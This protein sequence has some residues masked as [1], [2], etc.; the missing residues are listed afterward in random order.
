MVPDPVWPAPVLALVQLAD[1]IFC[2]I[3]TRFV[4]KC[5]DDVRLPARYRPLLPGLKLAA[6][7]G[8]TVGLWI[9]YL[10]AVTSACVAVYFVL[11]VGAH[12][13][14]KDIGR[15]MF[16]ASVILAFSVFVLFTFL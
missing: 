3:P 5:L 15:N 9:D 8:L 11:A 13:R 4:T 7:V 12:I 6:V 14:A 2:A 1:A 10:G 16:N